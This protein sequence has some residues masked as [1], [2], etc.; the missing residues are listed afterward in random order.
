ML[1]LFPNFCLE[2][3][4]LMN[5]IFTQKEEIPAL[6][7]TPLFSEFESRGYQ[8]IAIE[9]I[10]DTVYIIRLETPCAQNTFSLTE[11]NSVV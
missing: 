3:P 6:H 5:Q 4:N 11:R 9:N 10:A 1:H 2:K 8:C 7:I